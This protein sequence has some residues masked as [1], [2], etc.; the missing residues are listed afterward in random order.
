MTKR[1][2]CN[3]CAPDWGICHRATSIWDYTVFRVLGGACFS[4]GETQ[5]TLVVIL[6]GLEQP[7]VKDLPGTAEP[8]GSPVCE[9]I[10]HSIWF[11]YQS[12]RA[13]VALGRTRGCC[14]GHMRWHW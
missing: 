9:C 6:G 1:N 7:G 10:N 13:V 4:Q 2:K 8:Y 12:S 11:S 5:D 3:E 14:H